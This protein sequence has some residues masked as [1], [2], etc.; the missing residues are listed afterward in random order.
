MLSRSEAPRA[1]DASS[2]PGAAMA[3]S[4]NVCARRPHLRARSSSRSAVTAV[5]REGGRVAAVA[6]ESNGK[7]YR[8]PTSN[9]WSTLPVSL[10]VRCMSPE[11]PREVV[12]AANRISFRGMILIYLTLEQDRFTEY[13][14]HYFPEESIP[15]CRLSEPKNYSASR[16]PR[17]TTVLCAELP[18][19]PG[20]REWEMTDEQLGDLLR[21]GFSKPACR[22]RPRPRR[23]TTR[24]LR[25]AYPV[26]IR[27]YE[28]DLA[29]ADQWLGQIEGLLTFGRQ[30]LFVHDNTHHALYMA[31]AAAKCLSAPMVVSIM[32]FGPT[33]ARFLR[34][35]WWKTDVQGP[36]HNRTRGGGPATPS[37]PRQCGVLKLFAPAGRPG[38]GG[39]VNLPL[40]VTDGCARIAISTTASSAC[41]VSSSSLPSACWKFAARPDTCWLRSSRRTESAS[42]SANGSS[43][44]RKQNY[45]DLHFVTS[46]PEDLQLGRDLRLRHLQPPLRHG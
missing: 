16:E 19:D 11:A 5:E 27:G 40:I 39:R 7:S 1:R 22:C 8:I 33:T 23:V 46:D 44:W 43:K 20:T 34:R 42:R 24:R 28:N 14:A 35:T 30:A 25:Q 15:I 4:A 45:P 29:R 17:G 41:C 13:D 36:E 3:R 9:V 12:E 21:D 6:Y 31:N 38:G 32:R 10:L 37:T 26:Y 18:S 2:I